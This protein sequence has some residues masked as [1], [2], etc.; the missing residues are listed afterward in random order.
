MRE[1]RGATRSWPCGRNTGCCLELAHAHLRLKDNVQV[2][3]Q[4]GYTTVFG[5]YASFLLLR[6]GHV[7]APIGA[8]AFCNFMG[9]P[10]FSAAQ[11]HPRAVL[12]KILYPVGIVAFA[13]LLAPMSWPYMYSNLLSYREP[14]VNMYVQM[15]QAS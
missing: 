4:A 12:L 14:K 9:F 1:S 13:V 2:G 5:W 6:T 11:A 10:D 7:I 3:F 8:H 15:T